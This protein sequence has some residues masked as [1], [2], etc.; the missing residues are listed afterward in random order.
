MTIGAPITA[1]RAAPEIR[2]ER[3]L[4]RPH[5]LSDVADCVAMW[6]D[7]EIARFTIGEPSPASRT[8]QRLLGYRGHW[9]LLGFGYWAV[10]ENSS[11]RYVGDLGFADFRRDAHP[12]IDGLP[13]IGWALAVHAQGKGYA[14]EALRAVV[15]W[16]DGHFGTRRTACRIQRGNQASFRVADKLGYRRLKPATAGDE[17]VVILVRSPPA[18]RGAD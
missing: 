3:L 15:R 4:L 8:W 14:T 18:A 12:E 1:H 5:Q 10:V 6:A 7:P 16:G 13:E 11:G 9:T 2:T 17:P